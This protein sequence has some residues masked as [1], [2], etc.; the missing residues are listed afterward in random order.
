[1]KTDEKADIV[2]LTK[3][4]ALLLFPII[5]RLDPDAVMRKMTLEESQELILN[6]IKRE[7][8]L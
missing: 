5:S 4:Q 6:R 8:N 2:G 1:M 7:L 3:E